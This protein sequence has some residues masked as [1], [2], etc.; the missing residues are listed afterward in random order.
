M[1]PESLLEVISSF[2]VSASH[3]KT[4]DLDKA[5]DHQIWAFAKSEKYHILTKDRDFN[6]IL[7]L[8]GHPPKVILLRVGKKTTSD[9]L[10]IVSDAMPAI[11]SWDDEDFGLIQIVPSS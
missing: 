2:D 10:K 3:V 4:E 7:Q 8:H 1:L 6:D 11:I 9:I 5:T